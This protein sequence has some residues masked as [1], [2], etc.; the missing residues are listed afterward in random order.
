MRGKRHF[1]TV[2]PQEMQL[3]SMLRKALPRR[4]LQAFGAKS[5]IFSLLFRQ[6]DEHLASPGR[7]LSSDLDSGNVNP[8]VRLCRRQKIL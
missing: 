6:A 8:R 2:H 7:P 1:S 5:I 4:L 3:S